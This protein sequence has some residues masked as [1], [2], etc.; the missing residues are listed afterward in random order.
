MRTKTIT[1]L[2]IALCSAFAVPAI[3]APPGL[4][5]KVKPQPKPVQPI[6]RV[7]PNAVFV[8]MSQFTVGARVGASFGQVA[9]ELGMSP[10]GELQMS[11]QM[12][13][14]NRMVGLMFGMGYSAPSA[15]SQPGSYG[16]TRLGQNASSI[17]YTTTVKDFAITLGPQIFFP[18]AHAPLIPYLAG[19]LKTHFTTVE[20]EGSAGGQAFGTNREPRTRLGY[21][22]RGGTGVRLGPGMLS[23][24]LGF[25]GS[26]VDDAIT[27]SANAGGLITSLGYFIML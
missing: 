5:G 1:A 20:T 23:F 6:V 10:T 25:E 16:D 15:S 8:P 3:A 26:P 19:G 21:F 13:F 2:V 18:L 27:G 24:D 17:S 14:A 9:S 11:W 7:D 12:P 22:V 4:K